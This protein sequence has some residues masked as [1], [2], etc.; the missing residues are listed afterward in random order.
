M[1]SLVL[2]SAFLG[3]GAVWATE[4][5][6]DQRL[7]EVL[8]AR[9]EGQL[10]IAQLQVEVVGLALEEARREYDQGLIGEE[11]LLSAQ[12]RYHEAEMQVARLRLDSHEVRAT[13]REPQGDISAPLVGGRDFITE[14]LQLQ[15]AFAQEHLA[16][17]EKRVNRTQTLVEVGALSTES[18]GD[19]MLA[20]EEALYSLEMIQERMAL[21]QRFLKEG[22]TAE[23]AEVELQRVEAFRRLEVQTQA[24]ENARQ[25]F[26]RIEDLV[27]RGLAPQ[28][29]LAQ[30]RIQFLQLELELEL[31]HRTMEALGSG[32]RREY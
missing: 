31:V 7:Q 26:Q 3:A 14:R 27:E 2:L 22:M 30:A 5:V 23:E 17:L 11:A 16:T 6:Q 9:I 20:M 28:S 32:I 15:V 13:G 8:L 18:L 19:L 10:R 24:Y 21:R 29:E 4:Q 25:H 12:L 1:I